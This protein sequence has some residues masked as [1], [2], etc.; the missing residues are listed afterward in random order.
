[1]ANTHFIVYINSQMFS[2]FFRYYKKI[3]TI[4][5]DS[6]LGLNILDL[7]NL[8]RSSKIKFYLLFPQMIFIL[9]LI[10]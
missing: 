10:I 4:F 3:R 1:M 6:A 7:S 8:P 9:I 5:P 2:C